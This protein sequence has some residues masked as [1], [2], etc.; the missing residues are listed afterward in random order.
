M[1]CPRCNGL[2][3]Q[4]NFMDLKD[5]AG[6]C[7]FVAWHCLICGEVLDPVILK[8]RSAPPD[9]KVD[10]GRVGP[11]MQ[12]VTTGKHRARKSDR[13]SELVDDP[14]GGVFLPLECRGLATSQ[15]LA[16]WIWEMAVCE[17][18]VRM[19]SRFLENK[20]ELVR[21]TRNGSADHR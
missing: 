4:D 15:T 6:Q 19:C 1:D 18:S 16:S 5:E 12:F 21:R 11:K 7:R 9:S 13:R 2:M 14:G 3:A 20:S 8:N 10:R 17:K